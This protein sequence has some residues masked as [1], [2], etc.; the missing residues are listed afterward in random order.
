M[1]DFS[2]MIEEQKIT[3]ECVAQVARKREL[4][5]SVLYGILEQEKGKPGM[6]KKNSNGTVD[7]GATQINTVWIE[8]FGRKYGV[9]KERLRD[10]ACFSLDATG[11]IL[12]KEMIRTGG[13]L[14]KSVGNYHSRTPSVHWRYLKQV[15]PR[16]VR[17]HNFL[18]NSA[19]VR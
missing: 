13:D 5:A 18:R 9:S 15:H 2:F 6:E 19:G 7:V 17:Y 16:I 3:H 11:Y 10:D 14:W 4:P 8:Y 12:S 1:I